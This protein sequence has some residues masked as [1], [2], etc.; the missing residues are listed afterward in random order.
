MWANVAGCSRQT[1]STCRSFLRADV[2]EPNLYLRWAMYHFAGGDSFVCG[3]VGFAVCQFALIRVQSNSRRRWLTIGSRLG[4]VWAIAVLPPVPI[5]LLA[6]FV[7]TMVVWCW[8]QLRQRP[9][10][11]PVPT[12]DPATPSVDTSI[13][14]SPQ[15]R[16]EVWLR[17]CL[18]GL[19]LAGAAAE[20]IHFQSPSR[21]PAVQTLSVVGDSI[22]AGLNDGEDTW[23]R[24]VARQAGI[25]VLDASQPG[26]TL[27]SALRQVELLNP[28]DA[29]L[30]VLEIGGNDLLEGLPVDVFDRDLDRLLLA[31]QKPGRQT[32]MFELPLPPLSTR[33]G[34]AQRRHARRYGVPLIPRRQFLGVLTAS[35]A[36]VD[37]IHL[38]KTGQGRLANLMQNLLNLP[39]SS[40]PASG[41]YR[42]L[43]PVRQQSR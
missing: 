27:K 38:S 18:A 4:L 3:L 13:V 12:T 1:H 22:T 28:L 11:A 33:Y 30:L 29:D 37:G 36:T 20:A 17:S 24:K 43:E 25:Q 26:A 21:L 8:D 6:A 15:S 32:I 7:G 31:C 42:H 14:G 34:A 41:G 9:T 39:A 2:D 16:R 19:A 35:G 23:P 40:S 5:P 10:A